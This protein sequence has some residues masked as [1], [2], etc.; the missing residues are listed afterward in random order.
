MIGIIDYGMG[1]LFSVSKALERLG[2]D[3]FVSEDKKKLAGADALI[4][5]G[6]GSFKDAMERLNET[7][8]S[9]MVKQYAGSGKPLL[10]ICLGMQLLFAQSEENG[11]T[12]GLALLP[13]KVIRFSG[14]KAG[15]PYKVPH[16]GWNRLRFVNKSPILSGISEDFV[17]FVHSYYV[18]TKERNVV[19]A[20]CEY[21]VAVPAVVGKGNVY[22]MQFH[23]EKSGSLGMSLLQNFTQLTKERTNQS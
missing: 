14:E 16:M 22:G 19:I 6:V 13:G 10:G 1:N 4:L 18:N 12:D 11:Q 21:D 23:P 15:T 5:P 2:V 9:E 20:D 3:Y 17:Y 8:L 7:G